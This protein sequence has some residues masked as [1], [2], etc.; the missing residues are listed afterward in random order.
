MSY[1]WVA[2]LLLIKEKIAFLPFIME[3]PP[4]DFGIYYDP[5]STL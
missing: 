4:P 1:F 3:V 2:S 5:L